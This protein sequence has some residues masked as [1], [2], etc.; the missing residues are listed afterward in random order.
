MQKQQDSRHAAPQLWLP[1]H[2]QAPVKGRAQHSLKDKA[3]D[4]VEMATFTHSMKTRANQ[5]KFAHQLLCNPKV[6]TLLKAV[7]KGFLK[8][9][10]NLTKKLILNLP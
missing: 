6:S 9:C 8:G 3:R 4:V 7:R 1:C 10:P 2:D 5:V